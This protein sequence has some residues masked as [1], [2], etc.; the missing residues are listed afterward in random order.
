M[1][2]FTAGRN[3]ALKLPER[4]YQETVA[5]YT[6]VLGLEKIHESDEGTILDFGNIRLN[7]DRVAHQSQTDIWFEIE[8]PD[9]Q[10]AA[11]QLAKH[12]VSRCDEVEELPTGFDGF[13]VASPSGTIHLI[14]KAGKRMS[15]A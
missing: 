13:W 8:T 10:E 4:L 7:L 1:S 2:Q 9:T 6:D 14:S 12:G 15:Q 11:A 3:I 5:F